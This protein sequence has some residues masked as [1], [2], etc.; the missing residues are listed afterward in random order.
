M[1]FLT[2][3]SFGFEE[4]TNYVIDLYEK[5]YGIRP[6]FQKV[7]DICVNTLNHTIYE[8]WA[9]YEIVY[10]VGENNEK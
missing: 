4:R 2:A 7:E 6:S 3:Q 9:V 10:P 8:R 1:L 5:Y